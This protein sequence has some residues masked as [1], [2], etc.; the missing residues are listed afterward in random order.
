MNTLR[1]SVCKTELKIER[2]AL[3]VEKCINY[4]RAEFVFDESWAGL[5][6]TAVFWRGETVYHV[7]LDGENAC[8]IPWELMT[9]D[10]FIQIGVTGIGA[11]GT[12][13]A[14]RTPVAQS[15]AKGAYREGRIPSEPTPSLYEQLNAAIA[16]CTAEVA[17]LYEDAANGVF[18][19]EKGDKGDRG[20]K[21]DK[22][23]KGDQ[24][25]QGIQGIQGETGQKG[26]K[27][28]TGDTGSQGPQGIQ[29]IQ[30][31]KG[32]KGDQGIQGIQGVQ[33]VKGDTGSKG[34]KGDK[35]DT[36]ND[37]VSPTV[38]V[39]TST[40]T[41]YVLTVTDANGSF[42]TPNLK[43]ADGQGAGD[44]L[45]ATYD[46]QGKAQDVF[47]Y[48]DAAV[49]GHAADSVNHVTASERAAWNAKADA[50]DIPTKTSDLTNDS[51]YITGYTETDPTVPAWA[52]AANKPAYTASEVGAAS[53]SALTE[54]TNRTDNPHSVTAAQ[55]GALADNTTLPDL[56]GIL[57][58]S[59]GGTG[60]STIPGLAALVG[61]GTS[62]IT[63]RNINHFTNGNSG[64]APSENLITS[65]VLRYAINRST[66]VSSAD[67]N[68][69]TLMA[70]GASLNST[71][72]TPAVNGA[73]AWTYE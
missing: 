17:K 25:I 72:T 39:K 51:G 8:M 1:L 43:G 21:G 57:P 70:R 35:G 55:V 31:E 26:D 4:D 66:C 34:D 5:T 20:E 24:G 54:H 56:S 69:T 18:K 58:V 50:G 49:N 71:E 16:N 73:I 53:A 64:I 60:L 59:K 23:D 19:G 11:D 47:A 14:T 22:G 62:A 6:K 10:G 42:D 44:M 12:V 2:T 40:G 45:A 61:N 28:D 15:I 46:P 33:G 48:A 67:T 30:G 63:T 68:Y 37:G 7:L 36:G 38:T 3:S 29:G 32:E 65:G 13:V 52:K 27:G 9:E 41:Q